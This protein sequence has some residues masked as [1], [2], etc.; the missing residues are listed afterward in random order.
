MARVLRD[1]LQS[2]ETSIGNFDDTRSYCSEGDYSVDAAIAILGI[3]VLMLDRTKRFAKPNHQRIACSCVCV[4]SIPI[5]QCSD[6]TGYCPVMAVYFYLD[7]VLRAVTPYTMGGPG[8][9]WG[10]DDQD[11]SEHFKI[12]PED[13]SNVDLFRALYIAVCYATSDGSPHP[14]RS[15]VSNYVKLPPMLPYDDP[16]GQPIKIK[17]SWLFEAF[18][19]IDLIIR[20][21]RLPGAKHDTVPEIS[22]LSI[23]APAGAGEIG[24]ENG[25]TGKGV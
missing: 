7:C 9:C 6:E 5:C 1:E 21:A 12:F 14:L 25:S 15:V 23:E 10:K 8:I 3:G 13:E 20:Y 22:G 24:K 17:G 19:S 18:D 4:E 11:W 2:I 16:N